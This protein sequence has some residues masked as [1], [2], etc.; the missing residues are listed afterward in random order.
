ML[1]EA[2]IQ[3]MDSLLAATKVAASIISLDDRIG[4]VE[5]GK[6][7]D[8]ILMP[9]DP[10]ADV[11]GLEK[12]THVFQGGKLVKRPEMGRGTAGEF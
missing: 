1:R 3:P 9:G 10:L 6:I 7:A 4:T 2:G 11:S 12:V 5:P 8:L